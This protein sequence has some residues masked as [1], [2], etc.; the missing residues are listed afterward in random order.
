MPSK[1]R[2]VQHSEC[3]VV[4]PY[5]L[6]HLARCVYIGP[7]NDESCAIGNNGASSARVHNDIASNSMHAEDKRILFRLFSSWHWVLLL[8]YDE[9]MWLLSIQEAHP[10]PR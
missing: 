9:K 1:L 2:D 3:D 7:Y 5:R 10:K 8:L 4:F 6:L